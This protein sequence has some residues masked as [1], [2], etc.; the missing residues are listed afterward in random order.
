MG[1]TLVYFGEHFITDVLAGWAYAIVIHYLL[2]RYL[3]RRAL[4]KQA[5]RS[6]P[7]AR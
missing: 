7:A 4:R 6:E 1:F 2:T 5:A 3:D